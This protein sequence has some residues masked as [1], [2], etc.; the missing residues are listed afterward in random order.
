[1]AQLHPDTLLRQW[2]ML[3]MIPRY[4]RKITAKALHEQL[5]DKQF[6][7]TKRTVERDLLALSELF[8]LVSDERDKPYGWSWEKNAPLFDL[9]GLSHNE[10]LTLAMVEQHLHALLPASTLDQLEP[11]FKAARRHLSSI[12]QS[13]R[14]RSWL[15]KVRTVPPTQPLLAPAIKPNVQHAVY[16]ALLADRQLDIKYLKRGETETL[17]YRIHPLAL[18]Q[19][20]QII[21]LYCHFF[22]YEDGRLLALHRIQ[23]ATILDEKV[24]L[25]ANFSID[26]VIASGTL[27][28]S[29]GKTIKLEALFT[30]EAGEHLFETP[31]SKDQILVAQSDGRLRLTATVADTHQLAWWLLGFG[32]GVE[33]LKPAAMRQWVVKTIEGM[34]RIYIS[35]VNY[36]E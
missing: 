31:L 7:V 25:P 24:K 5:Q 23:S 9:P 34:R 13:G 1:M 30:R 21:Y 32:E 11:Y 6:D 2:Q 8:P 15:N 35:P 19:R 29:D 33:I 26:D 22:D 18:I 20:G 28:F 14:A 4:P 17:E 12:P 16:E 10:S 27:G 3:R 36:R